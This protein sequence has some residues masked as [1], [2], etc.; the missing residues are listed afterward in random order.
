MS[1]ETEHVDCGTC[2][3]CCRGEGIFLQPGDNPLLYRTKPAWDPVQ[4]RM[5]HL[6]PN[7]P[8][9]ACTYLGETGCTIYEKR[10]MIC[11]AFSCVGFV[12]NRLAAASKRERKELKKT[13]GYWAG[14]IWDAGMKRLG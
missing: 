11:R 1:Q 2:T 3:A 4:K 10:P 9:G 8:D 5:T 6:I 7:G 14:E 12:R 13:G